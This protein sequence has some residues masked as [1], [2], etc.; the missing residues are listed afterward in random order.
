MSKRSKHSITGEN[1]TISTKRRSNSRSKGVFSSEYLTWAEVEKREST[2]R[3]LQTNLTKNQDA[4][5]KIET[6]KQDILNELSTQQNQN[7]TLKG[8]IKAVF[9]ERLNLEHD[10]AQNQSTKS[11]ITQLLEETQI[12]AASNPSQQKPA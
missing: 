2:L 8:N 11:L 12:L 6:E 4:I 5:A 3:N 1:N 10:I 9:D 7:E